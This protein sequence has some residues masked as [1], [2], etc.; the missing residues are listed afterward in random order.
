MEHVLEICFRI[1]PGSNGITEVNEV[2]NHSGRIHGHHRTDPSEGRVLLFIVSNVSERSTPWSDKLLE[3]R[4]N[5]L[6]TDISK[7][8]NSNGCRCK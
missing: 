3:M 2:R 4:S 7:P 1:Y 5:F 8:S 6:R